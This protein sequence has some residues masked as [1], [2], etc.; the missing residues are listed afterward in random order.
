[1]QEQPGE[2]LKNQISIKECVMNNAKIQ[3]G[4]VLSDDAL[5][6]VVGGTGT[7]PPPDEGHLE[8]ATPPAE[9]DPVTGQSP[10]PTAGRCDLPSAPVLTGSTVLADPV[11]ST[12]LTANTGTVEPAPVSSLEPVPGSLPESD[13]DIGSVTGQSP[14]PTAG[15]EDVSSLVMPTGTESGTGTATAEPE[16]DVIVAPAPANGDSEIGLSRP[17]EL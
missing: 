16:K 1:M 2:V 7:L 4:K 9:P 12:T 14:P 15:R 13:S 11:V 8:L 17:P 10:P 5:D 3:S 6:R